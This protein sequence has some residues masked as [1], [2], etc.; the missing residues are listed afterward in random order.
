MSAK[1]SVDRAQIRFAR[2]EL[3]ERAVRSLLAILTPGQAGEVEK[4]RRSAPRIEG[5]RG[6]EGLDGLQDLEGLDAI[7]GGGIFTGG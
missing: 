3:D 6:L 1:A 5:I 7:G 4:A 2:T